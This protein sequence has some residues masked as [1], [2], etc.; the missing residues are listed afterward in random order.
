MTPPA[1]TPILPPGTL[2]PL[3][4]EL[5]RKAELEAAMIAAPQDDRLRGV[6]FDELIRFASTRTGLTHALLPELGYP[7]ALRC[8]SADVLALARTFRDRAYQFPLRA[9]PLRI[10][11]LGAYV[12]YAAVFL[13]QRFPA[14]QIVCVEPAAASFRVLGMNTL[15]YRQIRNFNLAAWHSATRL[16]V[17]T[18][19]FGDWGLQLHDQLPDGERSFPARSVAEILG[20]AGWDQVDLIVCDTRGGERAIFA[21]P[22]QRWVH[23]LDALAVMVGE[24]QAAGFLEQARS[25]FDPEDYHYGTHGEL[26]IIERQQPFRALPKPAPR[27]MPLVNCEPG[28]FPVGVQDTAQTSWGF[29][30]FDGDSCQVHANPP[31]DAPARA[32]F[33]RTLDGQARFTATILHA[34]RPA[35]PIVFTLI[36]AREDGVEVFRSS[37]TV[38]SG[39][40]QALDLDL[41]PL[42]GRHHLILQTEMA[43]G[44]P[45]N[46]N[47][48]AQWLAP[49]IG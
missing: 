45:Q 3:Q 5:L 27:E 10:L 21:D 20:F 1:D 13:A 11:V 34:G 7:I 4:Q 46:F 44:A 36:V 33:P 2:S 24:P 9:T 30:V 40:R 49:R 42:H 19:D 23:T 39:E 43:P 14:A 48:W 18:R 35:A 6:Y 17:K 16:G 32:L 12:G 25:S 31:G 8:G 22:G 37:H 15:P 28:L 41:P 38:A 26:Q 29:F 47:A